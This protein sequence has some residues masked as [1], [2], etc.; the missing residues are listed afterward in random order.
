[1]ITMTNYPRISI[2]TPNLNQVGFIEETID[3]VLSQNYPNLEYVIIDGGSTDGSLEIIKKY[4]KYLKYWESVPDDGLYHAVQKGFTHTSG[5][6]MAWINSDDR[7]H[8]QCFYT[9][10]ELFGEH[11]HVNWLMG[12][13]SL[14]D[15]KGRIVQVDIFKRWSKYMVYMGDFRWFQQESMF[16]RRS[17]WERAGGSLDLRKRYAADFELWLRFFRYEPL[18]LS[19]APLGCFRARQSGSVSVQHYDRYM[20]E[21]QQMLREEPLSSEQ[22]HTIKRIKFYQKVEKWPILRR[23]LKSEKHLR[24]LYDF[25]PYFIFHQK[26][27]KFGTMR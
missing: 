20:E 18:Y 14:I 3:S 13:P 7:Y 19:R 10:A 15:E 24:Q 16:W 17:L 1:M 22:K 25:P 4:S 11:P 12:T 8:R 26:E 23:F 27:Q 21:L 5:E 6:V 2:V 9:V